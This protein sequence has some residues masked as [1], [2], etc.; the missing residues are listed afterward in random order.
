MS[1]A[2]YLEPKAAM[3]VGYARNRFRYEEMAWHDDIR[4]FAEA[5]AQESGYN[6]L[7]EQPMSSIVLLSRLPKPKKLF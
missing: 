7:D 4:M 6:I 5:L 3:S 2:T 1:D